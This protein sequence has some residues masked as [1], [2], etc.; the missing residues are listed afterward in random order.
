MSFA[1]SAAARESPRGD[2][3]SS[4]PSKRTRA[5]YGS[6]N[7]APPSALTP[8][9]PRSIGSGDFLG[10]VRAKGLQ[11]TKC[12]AFFQRAR[13]RDLRLEPRGP[14]LPD[15]GATSESSCAYP[16]PSGTRV[17]ASWERGQLKSSARPRAGAA[18]SP[19]RRRIS[20]G[21]G[22]A[23]P[24]SASPLTSDGAP[25]SGTTGPATGRSLA[26]EGLVSGAATG[27]SAG[28]ACSTMRPISRSR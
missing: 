9:T 19:P 27:G 22:L 15:P 23:A 28:A 3:Q 12:I 7:G 2:C 6:S 20:E 26:G 25:V 8:C 16:G 1:G 21:P 24:R 18:S 17:G 14:G 13:S 10:V 11:A 5:R 4:R